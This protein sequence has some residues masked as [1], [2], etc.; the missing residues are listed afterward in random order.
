MDDAT[1]ARV[2]ADQQ[3]QMQERAARMRQ[4]GG[5][6]GTPAKVDVKREGSAADSAAPARASSNS[7]TGSIKRPAPAAVI[8]VDEDERLARQLQEEEERA[9]IRGSG[10][11]GGSSVA[12]GLGT[13]MTADDERLAHKLQADPVNHPLLQQRAE[14][15]RRLAELS[16][17]QVKTERAHTALKEE[18]SE[19]SDN[20]DLL[21]FRAFRTQ[22]P[23]A[24]APA[25]SQAPTPA[26]TP[27]PAA[28]APAPAAAPT[29][30]KQSKC[31]ACGKTGHSRSSAQCAMYNHPAE[32]KRREEAAKRKEDRKRLEQQQADEHKRKLEESQAHL[33]VL[34]QQINAQL[35]HAQQPPGSAKKR[36]K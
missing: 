33:Q 35:A 23:V 12:G 14:L 6:P 22:P 2:L 27:A 5:A 24:A 9:Y 28:G 30:R 31:G 8:N 32:V 18:P 26:P 7:A 25:R 16:D 34:L 3:R 19:D 29:P 20:E 17:V 1:Y 15:Q 21:N 4:S 10:S 11:S 36:K 13:A